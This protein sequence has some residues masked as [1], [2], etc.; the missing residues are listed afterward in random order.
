[1]TAFVRL[2][3]IGLLVVGISQAAADAAELNKLTPQEVADGW[4]LLFD[5]ETTFGWSPATAANW[6]VAD[7]VISVAQRSAAC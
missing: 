7:G 6:A 4:V 2:L 1:M 5:G 3:G